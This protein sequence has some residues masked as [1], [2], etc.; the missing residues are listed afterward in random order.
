M[1]CRAVRSTAFSKFS[2]PGGGCGILGVWRS[3]QYWRP[4][5]WGMRG[6]PSA[7]TACG[8]GPGNLGLVPVSTHLARVRPSEGRP[9]PQLNGPLAARH[10][11]VN[12]GRVDTVLDAVLDPARTHGRDIPHSGPI[13]SRR[14][15]PRCREG[16]ARGGVRRLTTEQLSASFGVDIA[17]LYGYQDALI[18]SPSVAH[19]GCNR[20]GSS[21]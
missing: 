6:R 12:R 11:S 10:E 21:R 9:P 16:Q 2:E 5:N 15:G 8:L 3:C 1:R 4:G 18:P 13:R 17:R 14:D 20:L 7:A 19:Q